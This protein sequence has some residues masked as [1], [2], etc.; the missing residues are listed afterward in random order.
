[1]ASFIFSAEQINSAPP[2][3]RQWMVNEIGAALPTLGRSRHEPPP[4]HSPQLAA[5]TLDKTI[6]VFDLLQHDFATK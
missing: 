5:C 1:M 4:L 2:E 6:Q 3:V